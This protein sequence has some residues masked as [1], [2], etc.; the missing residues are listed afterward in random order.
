MFIVR[1]DLRANIWWSDLFNT[2]N[3]KDL[4]DGWAIIPCETPDEVRL[5]GKSNVSVFLKFPFLRTFIMLDLVLGISGL[6]CGLMIPEYGPKKY[7]RRCK[8]FFWFSICSGLF[9][10]FSSG[11][12]SSSS[13][14]FF[15]IWENI[16]NIF[17]CSPGSFII[18]AKTCCGSVLILFTLDLVLIC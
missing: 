16:L 11:A 12:Q 1:E 8:S 7:Y 14:S 2:P 3:P 4:R 15:F 13:E 10:V 9:G 5:W 18:S 6:S 17:S